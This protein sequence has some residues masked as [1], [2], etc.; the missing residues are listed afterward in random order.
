MTGSTYEY[1][2]YGV[3][4]S[5]CCEAQMYL[6]QAGHESVVFKFCAKCNGMRVEPTLG[7]DF[8]VLLADSMRAVDP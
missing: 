6:H 5:F 1:A 7:P 2:T 4:R 8:S 3:S